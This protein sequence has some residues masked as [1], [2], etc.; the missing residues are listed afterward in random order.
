MNI[1]TIIFLAVLA[2]SIIDG[3]RKGFLKTA[4]S[5]VA[6]VVVLI[7]CNF[8]TPIVTDML[9]EKTDIEVV[10][11][12]TVDTKIDEVINET[13]SETMES[14]D[15]TELEAALPDGIKDI[16]LGENKS[17][18]DVLASGVELDTVGLTNGIVGILGFVITVILLRLAMLVVEVAINIV[19][20]LPLIGPMDKFLGLACGAGKGIILCWIIWVVASMFL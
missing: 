1:L 8:V 3:Y 12:T 14:T 9:V 4:F 18:Q 20:K 15:L 19:G 11:Q 17:L 13:I 5:L 16:L 6:W 2:L 10:I 7:L